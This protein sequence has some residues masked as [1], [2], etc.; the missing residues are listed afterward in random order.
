MAYNPNIPATAKNFFALINKY[1]EVSML[2]SYDEREG[3]F[4]RVDG[5]WEKITR[6]SVRFIDGLKVMYVS[7]EA[8]ELIDEM[9]TY[10]DAI[11]ERDLEKYSTRELVKSE[12]AGKSK[13]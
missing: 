13:E 11:T 3:M 7:P 10:S 6:E 4:E 5:A 2:I 12:N 8:I 9:Y 1:G